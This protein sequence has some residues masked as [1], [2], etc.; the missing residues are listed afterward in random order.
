MA[1]LILTNTSIHYFIICIYIYILVMSGSGGCMFSQ[2]QDQYDVG[3][4]GM[5]QYYGNMVMLTDYI[6]NTCND[7]ECNNYRSDGK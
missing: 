1:V 4:D 3:I 7:S 5:Q 6:F 2:F